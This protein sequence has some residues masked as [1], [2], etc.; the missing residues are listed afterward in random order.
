MAPKKDIANGSSDKM[1]KEE[2]RL[3]L[4]S[5]KQVSGTTSA[6]FYGNALV[7]S[8]LPVCECPPYL[9]SQLASPGDCVLF[10]WWQGCTGECR[11][12]IP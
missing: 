10:G 11:F 9:H 6:L 3:L 8:A 5:S 1:T 2:E 12:W 4:E 7:V